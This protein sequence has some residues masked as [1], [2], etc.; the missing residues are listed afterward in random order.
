MRTTVNVDD[1]LLAQ[2]KLRAIGAHRTIGEVLNDA[3]RAYL[4]DEPG[5]PA[6]VDL[7]D[8]HYVGGITVDLYDKDALNAMLDD[9]VLDD[10]VS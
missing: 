3:L 7:P 4:A 6:T 8:F 10:A 1:E 2:A 5:S 9:S